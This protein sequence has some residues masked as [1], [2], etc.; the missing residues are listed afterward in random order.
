MTR[1]SDCIKAQPGEFTAGSDDPPPPGDCVICPE[2]YIPDV[3]EAPGR[4]PLPPPNI[5][6]PPPDIQYPEDLTIIVPTDTGGGSTEQDFIID[7]T[8]A[9]FPF[10]SFSLFDVPNYEGITDHVILDPTNENSWQDSVVEREVVVIGDQLT[11]IPGDITVKI[12]QFP[13]LGN[14]TIPQFEIIYPTTP[15][16]REYYLT[17]PQGFL[18]CTFDIAYT[19]DL[20]NDDPD[21]GRF[22]VH[23]Q[24]VVLGAELQM[25]GEAGSQDPIVNFPAVA[26][27][28]YNSTSQPNTVIQS[29][30]WDL[31]GQEVVSYNIETFPPASDYDETPTFDPVNGI[32]T[33]PTESEFL[34]NPLIG[35][36]LTLDFSESDTITPTIGINSINDGPVAP[37][38]FS[39]TNPESGVID[40]GVVY[41]E[42]DTES[43]PSNMIFPTEWNFNGNPADLDKF[44]VYTSYV[45]PGCG[46]T[47]VC[48]PEENVGGAYANTVH[49]NPLTGV[50]TLDPWLIGAITFSDLPGDLVLQFDYIADDPS[51]N[52]FISITIPLEYQQWVGLAMTGGGPGTTTI[53]SPNTGRP[54]VVPSNYATLKGSGNFNLSRKKYV[55]KGVV[56]KGVLNIESIDIPTKDNLLRL[57]N[58]R[59]SDGITN[60][61]YTFYTTHSSAPD[62]FQSNKDNL[63]FSVTGEPPK[64]TIFNSQVDFTVQEIQN[65]NGNPNDYDDFVYNAINSDKVKRSLSQ[66]ARRS[67][68]YR[69]N[70]DGSK[71]V[72]TIAESTLQTL[73]NNDGTLT[74]ED[75]DNIAGNSNARSLSLSPNTAINKVNAVNIFL[76]NSFSLNAND[77]N[78]LDKNRILNWKV[79]AEEV[80]K[81]LIFKTSDGTESTIYIPN[82]ELI[83]VHTSTGVEH[84]LEMQDGD[85]FRANSV[86]GDD[87]LTVHSNQKQ[88][89][90][91]SREDLAKAS[92]LA[93]GSQYMDL[94]CTSLDTNLVELNV[95]TTGARAEYYF[96]TID[97]STIESSP[98]DDV[99]FKTVKATYDYKTSE[100][101]INSFIK[102]KLPYAMV[103][104]RS[105]D[106]IFNHLESSQK[107][108][109]EVN[110]FTL[111]NFT[112]NAT[113][114]LPT[115]MP[116]YII[117]IPSDKPSMLPVYNRSKMN[118]FNSRTIRVGFSPIGNTAGDGGE[119]AGITETITTTGGVNFTPDILGNT[120]YQEN[121]EYS[122]NSAALNSM[123][124]YKNNA[125][126]LP[127]KLHP[128]NKLLEKINTLKTDNSLTSRDKVTFYD[129]YS[130]MTPS[131]FRGLEADQFNYA[132]FLGKLR[133]NKVAETKEVNTD[134]FVRVKDVSIINDRTSP[135]ILPS[136]GATVFSKSKTSAEDAGD[137]I[138]APEDRGGGFFPTP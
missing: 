1:F 50:I 36:R 9:V 69:Y 94:T 136:D 27:V 48:W 73:I 40:P 8:T 32:L 30:P 101:E 64:Q 66:K 42:A 77:Y 114:I 4:I 100:S 63:N 35:T 82:S 103:T 52:V 29:D 51:H 113:K 28:Y 128:T 65:I 135:D 26:D 117:I 86:T 37:P 124:K 24:R 97:K 109:V 21:V 7:Q 81:H 68:S 105:D 19:A 125:E 134:N 55:P 122:L 127:R 34:S 31:K 132:E 45:E 14:D 59:Y 58:T 99:Y 6:I 41:Y 126:S 2:K 75:V 112:N 137:P 133:I 129:L 13:T 74:E 72:D 12:S 92:R 79:L 98:T 115:R 116:W 5:D 121:R 60:T 90:A 47:S 95:D 84:T 110:Q 93:G 22:E 61:N 67:L 39:Y 131:E 111:D 11:G 118:A 43:P 53:T 10:T 119:F 78:I 71:L 83:T 3:D 17:N 106:I 89:V 62:I 49:F 80:D 85:Y 23:R 123:P 70:L 76:N 16:A 25:V 54:L 87:R 107:A 15:E 56:G 104:L 20:L 33:F 138:T 130:R 120:I 88:A 102:H 46:G 96:L 18:W 38:V 44:T 57:K 91:L 108:T